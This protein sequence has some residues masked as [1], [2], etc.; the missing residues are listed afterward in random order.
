MS[1]RPSTA[2]ERPLPKRSQRPPPGFRLARPAQVL[3]QPSSGSPSNTSLFV[4]VKRPDE[5][6]GILQAQNRILSLVPVPPVST[7]DISSP[8]LSSKYDT[9]LL[10]TVEP[11]TEIQ[12]KPKRRRNTTNAVSYTSQFIFLLKYLNSCQHQLSEWM[13]FREAFLDEALRHD[14]LGNF[15]DQTKCSNCGNVPGIIKCKNCANGVLLKCPE[16][17]VTSH[18]SLLLHRVEVSFLF[19]FAYLMGT[20]YVIIFGRVG[21]VNFS[22]RT[23]FKTM[24]IDI[25]LV[26][27][28]DDVHVLVLAPRTSPSS[29]SLA[30]ILLPSTIVSAVT[31][32]Y[33]CEISCFVRDGSQPHLPALRPFSPLTVSKCFMNL[34]CKGRRAFMTITTP[35]CGVQIMQTLEIP[36]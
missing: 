15:L 3:L 4:T 19:F 11:D 12:D 34:L 21:T 36:L 17:I 22:T 5:Q 25:N 30:L 10:V 8:S 6:C 14:G 7:A 1:K 18:K 31:N 23:L 35:S 29:I 24:V 20:N 33:Q 26:I 32:P 9:S 27:L 13:K 16:C 2:D 28:E